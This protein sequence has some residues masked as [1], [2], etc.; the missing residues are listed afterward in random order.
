MKKEKEMMQPFS[1]GTEA[2]MWQEQ[3]CERCVRAYWP[4][5]EDWPKDTTM[6]HYISIGKECKLKYHIDLGFILGEIPVE[7]ALQIGAKEN[8]YSRLKL[9]WNCIMFSDDEDDG[10]HPPKRPKRPPTPDIRQAHLFPLDT[11]FIELPI[12]QRKEKALCQTSEN[13]TPKNS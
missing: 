3:N 11:N 8:E 1:N 9:P 7:I 10:Y 13:I 5:G 12:I 4:K 6:R 2:M